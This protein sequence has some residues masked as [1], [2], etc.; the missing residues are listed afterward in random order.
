M[1]LRNEFK[2]TFDYS[3]TGMNSSSIDKGHRRVRSDVL[4]SQEIDSISKFSPPKPP[5]QN[6]N[7]FTKLSYIPSP[8]KIS[9]LSSNSGMGFTELVEKQSRVNSNSQYR[10]SMNQIRATIAGI[11]LLPE[12]HTSNKK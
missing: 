5:N 9:L 3:S 6:R 8:T 10:K 12:S 1:K 7:R 11:P 4:S 2:S